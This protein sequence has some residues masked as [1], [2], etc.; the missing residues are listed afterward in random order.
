MSTALGALALIF[1]PV[2]CGG[3][4]G[5][6]SVAGG[7]TTGAPQ[8]L[9][10][11][12][13][14]VI[15]EV[16]DPGGTTSAYTR[17]A[18][19]TRAY[20]D[21][22]SDYS[23]QAKESWSDDAEALDIIN[24]I[25]Q[26]CADSEYE[27]FVNQGPYKA[28]VS[29]VGESD[30]SQGGSSSSNQTTEELMEVI[31][32]VTRA[33]SSA[34]M[35]IR[36]WVEEDDGPGGD[37][38]RIRGYFEVTEG[39][40]ARYPYGLMEAHFRGNKLAADGTEGD[41]TF[42]MALKLGAD[43]S[44]NAVVQFTDIGSED[45]QGFTFEWEERVRIISDAALT[46]GKAYVYTKETDFP[47][48]QPTVIESTAYIAFNDQYMKVKEGANTKVYDKDSLY[49]Q[50]YRY[51]L[52]D[53]GTGAAVQAANSGFPVTFA[54][55]IHGY[56]G[57]YGLW[58]P[59]A[60]NVQNGTVATNVHTGEQYTVFM[61]NG[62]LR[63]HT[64]AQILL[65]DLVDAEFSFYD[66]GNDYVLTWT[67]TEFRRIGER[68]NQNG[69]V[70]YLPPAQQVVITNFN[71][72]EGAWC[73][74]MQAF[75]NLGQ[76]F[77]NGGTPENSDIVKY[78]EEATVFPGDLDVLANLTLYH[79]GYVPD[80]PIDQA[81]VNNA[82][83]A[84][85]AYWNQ[86]NQTENEFTF[87][88]LSFLLR[89]QGGDAVVLGDALALEN[90][91]YENGLH[92]MPL[93]TQSFSQQ[94]SWQA[95]QEAIFYSW[96]TGQDDWNQFTTLVNAAGVHL[97][98]DAPLTMAYTHQTA[99]DINNEATHNGKKFR[100]EY[101]G[102]D[103]HIPWEFD[104]GEDDWR[105]LINLKDGTAVSDGTNNYV[106]KGIEEGLLMQEAPDPSQADGLIIDETI[107]APTF[108]YEATKT[109]LVG[110]V[111]TGAELKVVLGELID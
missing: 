41:E 70:D 67:G 95:H 98:F 4:G 52:F 3:G 29:P 108:Q 107:E 13:R 66:D 46:T 101:D 82:R 69:Q 85:E 111:P 56:V 79:W 59:P 97:K 81:A 55:G 94:N 76:L 90:T 53:A 5:G 37:P 92:L 6:S 88:F 86:Q 10:I 2:G 11:P 75:L 39:V 84:E 65:G 1:T 57:Y 45:D 43:T 33:N 89:D 18:G 73:E 100:L 25:L 63:R 31:L 8:A 9:S 20:N 71:E 49:H 44:G 96:E 80:A 23:N 91:R 17:A 60:A 78:H 16:A 106:V 27:N 42:N 109:A 87:D 14:V 72:W 68:N 38:M 24:D 104:E 36:I 61:V 99:N 102:S 22:G 28:M 110:A 74:Q 62:K 26:V 19:S 35:I 83:A 7:G 105:P 12:D 30:Q 58:A 15:T 32:D 77:A 93:T 34:P 54:S 47:Q 50:I 48:G 103:L 40:S 51:R 64:A 21:A